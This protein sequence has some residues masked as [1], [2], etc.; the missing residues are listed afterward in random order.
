[1]NL[2]AHLPC[3][4]PLDR[5]TWLKVGGLSLGA[6]AGGSA[7]SMA[8]LLAATQSSSAKS[9]VSSAAGDDF[10][11][12]LFWANG[13]PSHLD[14]FDLKPDAPA[15]IRGPFRPIATRVPG[16]EINELLPKLSRI[17]D[18]WMLVRSLCHERNEH[19]G[20]THRFLTGYSSR[21]ANLN[22][23][24]F[25]EVGSIVAKKLESRARAIPTFM[26][27]TKLYGSG[28]AYLGPAYAP[29]MP[30]P[31][32][33]TSTGSN[34]YDPVPIYNTGGSGDILSISA[35][36]VLSLDRRAALLKNL[37]QLP[38]QFDATGMME[39]LDTFQQQAVSMLGSQRTR[40]AFDLAK[41]SEQTRQRYG[42]TH[43]GDSLLT[44]RRLVEAGVRFVQCQAEFRLKP[45]VGRTS[46]WDDHAVN[47]HIFQGLE[48]KLP[49]LD[50]AVSGL[51]EDLHVRGL[52]RRVLFIFCGEFGRTPRISYDKATGRPGRDHWARAMSVFLAG[53]GLR[54]GQVIGSTNRQGEEPVERRMDSNCLLA[55]LYHKFG[56]D[57]NQVFHDRANRPMAILPTGEP[58]RELI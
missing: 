23:S 50:H 31:N 27:N 37:D 53:G 1:M 11:V 15:E 54:M 26:A 4:G 35:D 9:P 8:Q 3:P 39:S 58:I 22:D 55:T 43:W 36:G 14:I 56:I 46:N 41:E 13:G 21:A 38:R 29:Y 34:T 45:E 2:P 33:L 18:K 57:P 44:C 20:G 5:R 6:L 19:S 30:G 40:E 49:N 32:P 16:M 7:L 17:A 47:A 12:I 10:S 42:R 25:P 48:A 28:P 24:E 52:N 51:I